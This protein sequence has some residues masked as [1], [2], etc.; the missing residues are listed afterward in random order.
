M[1]ACLGVVIL[2]IAGDLTRRAVH[3]A[4][5]ETPKP[6]PGTKIGPDGKPIMW[7]PKVGGEVKDFALPDDAGT[8]RHLSDFKGKG[9]FVLTFFCGCEACGDLARQLADTYHRNPKKD[10]PTVS[11]FT[12]SWSPEGT[13]SWISRT[14]AHFIYLYSKSDP[15]LVD[16][17]HG[18]PCPRVF[19][20]DKNLKFRYVGPQPNLLPSNQPV[21][22]DMARVLGLKYK[23]PAGGS[24]RFND[25]AA[26][27]RSA[28]AAAMIR[29]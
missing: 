21:L 26:T 13:P 12:A 6:V 11:V 3:P 17:Y 20:V 24:R 14:N 8:I 1:L 25:N 4:P 9:N 27:S 16:L 10:V 28:R 2:L 5:P 15:T 23:P 7:Q 19:V 18:H 22:E 29:E